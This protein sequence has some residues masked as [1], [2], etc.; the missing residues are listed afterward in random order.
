M[1]K[2]RDKK[3]LTFLILGT[4]FL[5]L[6]STNMVQSRVTAGNPI[7][8]IKSSPV[9]GVE[10]TIDGIVHTTPWSGET[11]VGNHILDTE[12]TQ[13]IDGTDYVFIWWLSPIFPYYSASGF[14]PVNIN[15]NEDTTITMNLR[16]K[17][18]DKPRKF[19]YVIEY[20]EIVLQY[21]ND[22]TNFL[23]DVEVCGFQ[24]I[25]YA[26]WDPIDVWRTQSISY[27][28]QMAEYCDSH[29]IELLITIAHDLTVDETS[30]LNSVLDQIGYHPSITQYLVWTEWTTWNKDYEANR[31]AYL[32]L[33]AVV[34]AHG[35]PNF[36]QWLYIR[37]EK[38]GATKDEGL[39]WL[40]SADS[41]FL[42]HHSI[43]TYEGREPPYERDYGVIVWVDELSIVKTF[44]VSLGIWVP[45]YFITPTEIIRSVETCLTTD[46][47]E[48]ILFL[49]SYW[50]NPPTL[51]DENIE[52]YA[53]LY[54]RYPNVFIKEQP[55][56]TTT[57]NPTVITTTITTVIS[58]QIITM[59]SVI[60]PITTTITAVNSTPITIPT[61]IP[62][63]TIYT[64]VSPP[65]TTI[66]TVITST[67]NP[68]SFVE[69]NDIEIFLFLAADVL[70]PILL[71]TLYIRRRN[72]V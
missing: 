47:A 17:K 64:T 44:R 33:K 29:G 38:Y 52:T 56:T 35:I 24:T 11:T 37:A 71:Y 15:I 32:N 45:G 55:Y 3:I 26:D 14:L 60:P 50:D 27:V 53:S 13:N 36:G 48:R 57:T 49:G 4:I 72:R 25:M 16:A 39:A 66:T 43:W 63:T 9:S 51:P 19:G 8:N 7:L 22:V 23:N 70:I 30:I 12:L 40:N 21:N 69:I 34:N 62:S 31:Q 41:T 65:P 42:F 54:D 5:M 28:K 18:P 61:V 2:R 58:P 20:R 10:F 68:L 67:I 59:E 1:S 46:K 6:I